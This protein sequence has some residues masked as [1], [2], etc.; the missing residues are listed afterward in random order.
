M[1]CLEE[2]ASPFSLANQHQG[3]D[4][5]GG[6]EKPLGHLALPF[7]QLHSSFCHR[8]VKWETVTQ[9][10]FLSQIKRELEL[11]YLLKFY[12]KGFAL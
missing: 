5:E 8:T 10:L 9:D 1:N 2:G 7:W 3:W 6:R 12:S 4:E 11:I